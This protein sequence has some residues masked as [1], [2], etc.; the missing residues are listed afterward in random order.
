MS[1]SA[2]LGQL[3][4]SFPA[5]A[6]SMLKCNFGNLQREIDLLESAGA[7]VLHLDVM[8]GHF[9]PNLSYGPM[10]ISRIRKLTNCVLDA[11]LMI[12]NPQRYLE[13]YRDAGC[14]AITV[15]VEAVSDPLPVLKRIREMDLVAGLALNPGTPV[16][17]IEPA[18]SECDLILV[19][20]VE[21]G[22]GGQQFIP[23]SL[24]KLRTLSQRISVET[25]LSVDGGISPAT[26]GESAQ[27]G[28]NLFV[29]G[30]SVFEASD[31]RTAIE[32]MKNIALQNSQGVNGDLLHE[33][34]TSG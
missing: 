7:E 16:D 1:R 27:A 30:S 5:I 3:R 11:H 20:S 29:S 17:A 32:D 6:P 33:T 8:D 28:A 13:E 22:F 4:A 15:H 34:G 10:V 19:M 2:V 24:E 14:D 23:E 26:I 18:F 9:V 21:P 31:Y 12:S 25:I